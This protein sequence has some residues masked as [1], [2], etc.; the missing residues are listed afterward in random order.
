MEEHVS[1][2][3]FDSSLPAPGPRRSASEIERHMKHVSDQR[4]I[5]Q[6]QIK[7]LDSKLQ[8]LQRLHKNAVYA[9]QSMQWRK[10][11]MVA[12]DVGDSI[13]LADDSGMNPEAAEAP[14]GTLV[15]IHGVPPVPSC[16]RDYI[17]L[18]VCPLARLDLFLAT[19]N[20]FVEHGATTT[21]VVRMD[22]VDPASPPEGFTAE[23]CLRASMLWHYFRLRFLPEARRLFRTQA[24]LRV[25]FWVEDDCKLE[26]NVTV[27][28]L[29]QLCQLSKS[30]PMWL[31]WSRTEDGVPWWGAHLIGF[32][33]LAAEAAAMWAET[34][35]GRRRG[36]DTILNEFAHGYQGSPPR[37]SFPKRS[38]AR[39]RRHNLE[40][41]RTPADL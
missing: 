18:V 34:Y 41:R 30:M 11:P 1:S 8:F 17:F 22:G 15:D 28:G 32:S 40:G 35:S 13:V 38:L 6:T 9:E 29:V 27:D 10:R 5:L 4:S 36:L 33:Q 24:G 19:R 23:M 25:V 7:Q 20:G 14:R 26:D 39:Q 31:G 12:Q 3:A 2:C 37:L 16:D 21:S